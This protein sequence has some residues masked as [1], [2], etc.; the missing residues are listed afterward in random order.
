MQ[1]NWAVQPLVD[2]LPGILILPIPNLL[3]YVV[4]IYL[5]VVG[6]L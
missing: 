6:V 2:L 4:A 1:I 3:N 5:V